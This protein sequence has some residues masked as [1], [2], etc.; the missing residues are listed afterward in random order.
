M[1]RRNDH[2]RDDLRQLILATANR[3]IDEEGPAALTARKLAGAIGYT[4]G[5][6]YNVFHNLD[7]II[8]HV[9][10][11]TLQALH[12]ALQS[13][14]HKETRPSHVMM[15]VSEAYIAFFTLHIPRWRLISQMHQGQMLPQGYAE[16]Y[17]A[18]LM[19]FHDAL[20]PSLGYDKKKAKEAAP[21]VWAALH[22]MCT[23]GLEYVVEPQ[24]ELMLRAQ[25]ESF[26]TSYLRGIRSK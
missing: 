26:I 23:L 17:T 11:Q 20:L 3:L 10:Q 21:V 12:D 13:A 18:L 24:P 1:A 2:S 5:T 7:D 14:I 15:T 8:H 4:V 19:L 16:N 25:A 9:N 6:L 22:G